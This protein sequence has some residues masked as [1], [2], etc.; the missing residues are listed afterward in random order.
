[1]NIREKLNL[2][3]KIDE[4]NRKHVEEWKQKNM[5]IWVAD[6]SGKDAEGKVIE[7]TYVDPMAC[8]IQVEAMTIDDALKEAKKKVAALA[9][10]GNWQTWLVW[11]ISICNENVW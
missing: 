8:R 3:K 1:M 2:M 6:Y 11:G 4:D 9:E 7:S 10:E 5:K